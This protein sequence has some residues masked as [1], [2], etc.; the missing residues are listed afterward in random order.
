M[1]H[2]MPKPRAVLRMECVY[3]GGT[4]CD[5]D[6]NFVLLIE[7]ERVERWP[8]LGLSLRVMHSPRRR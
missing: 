3:V 6:A 8:V 4:E 1:M 7:R 5:I 2:D